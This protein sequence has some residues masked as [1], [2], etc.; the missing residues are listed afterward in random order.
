MNLFIWGK[1]K[2]RDHV[3]KLTE[4]DIRKACNQGRLIF[5]EN[6]MAEYTDKQGETKT[7]SIDNLASCLWSLLNNVLISRGTSFT[8]VDVDTNDVKRIIIK[9]REKK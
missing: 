9:I 8:A 3:L 1:S 5:K 6:D 2:A 7:Y 4:D